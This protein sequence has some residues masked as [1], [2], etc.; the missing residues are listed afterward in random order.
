MQVWNAQSQRTALRAWKDVNK[1]DTDAQRH[2][3]VY[4]H[5]QQALI[6]LDV[7]REYVEMLKEITR[8]DMTMAGDVT[9]ENRVGQ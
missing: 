7:D 6:R 9:K 5:A 2:K 4:D 8:E 3:Q 1:Q